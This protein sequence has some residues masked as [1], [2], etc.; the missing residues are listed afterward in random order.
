MEYVDELEGISN[1]SHC[2]GPECAYIP[3]ANVV[4]ICTDNIYQITSSSHKS[5]HVWDTSWHK[6]RKRDFCDSLCYQ[7]SSSFLLIFNDLLDR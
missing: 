4:I 3:S 7:V 5:S 2:I 1:E 6:N